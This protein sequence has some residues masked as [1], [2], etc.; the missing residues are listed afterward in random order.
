MLGVRSGFLRIC[1]GIMAF[2][3]GFASTPAYPATDY[4][5]RR[6]NADTQL[7]TFGNGAR[8]I[9][10]ETHEAPLVAM[11]I[12]IA[13][14]SS[15]ETS[16]NNGCAHF[17]EHLIFKGSIGQTNGFL[18]LLAE[19]AGS[20]V[21]ATTNRDW[22]HYYTTVAGR[23][24]EPLYS[25]LGQAIFKPAL[26]DK[27]IETER[28]VIQDE[29]ARNSDNEYRY[30]VQRLFSEWYKNLSYALPI[31][32][33][34][35]SINSIRP[36]QVKAFHKQWY[37]GPNIVFVLVGDIDPEQAI[38]LTSE[39]IKGIPSGKRVIETF[40]LPKSGKRIEDNG[41]FKISS[42]A[43]AFPAPS[44]LSP[45]EAV[46]L[47]FILSLLT[48]QQV[49]RLNSCLK[50]IADTIKGTYTTTVKPGLMAVVVNTKEAN[51]KLCEAALLGQFKSLREETLSSVEMETVRRRMLGSALFEAE[52]FGGR[53]NLLGFYAT[54]ADPDIAIRYID[55][56]R[57]L[58]P[59]D[60][61]SAAE[62]YL[63]PS[64][65]T[66]LILHGGK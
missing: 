8:L 53:A 29:I 40:I 21:D 5:V 47:D 27:D 64:L 24:W 55:M 17:L 36:D 12:W 65:Q 22:A 2:W 20:I 56:V 28:S 35:A 30:I 66:T 9:I 39:L 37:I 49:G 15:R 14:G 44:A 26:N 33:S 31:T 16:L 38:K 60:I 52:T 50:E 19:S 10:Q 59:R 18:D 43:I 54:I 58:T 63:D 62:R 4:I 34:F 46:A 3:V 13:A 57:S 25:A 41:K 23:Y 48:D 45:K 1:I 61:K 42:V 6:L 11:D 7:I 32:G 51:L